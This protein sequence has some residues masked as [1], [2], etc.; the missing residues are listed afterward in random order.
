MF[1]WARFVLVAVIAFTL[2]RMAAAQPSGSAPRGF[3]PSAV[4]PTAFPADERTIRKQ[5]E[6]KL[7]E[8][9]ERPR[10]YRIVGDDVPE[11]E[12]S[13]GILPAPGRIGEE[14]TSRL[15]FPR[16]A[17]P[18]DVDEYD[19]SELETGLPLFDRAVIAGTCGGFWL[20]FVACAWRFAQR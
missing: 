7:W 14:K 9:E 16:R 5:I 10:L 4:P 2:V 20:L 15:L 12:R 11:T 18:V 3:E 6:A 13:L 17:V 8:F 19:E 1:M